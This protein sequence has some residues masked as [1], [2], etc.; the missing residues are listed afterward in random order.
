MNALS[1]SVVRA[2]PVRSLR[3]GAARSPACRVVEEVPALRHVIEKSSRSIPLVRVPVSG[4]LATRAAVHISFTP[5]E[6][7]RRSL[8]LRDVSR[9]SRC[10]S[11]ALRSRCSTGHAR[12]R[13][14]VQPAVLDHQFA[15]VSRIL[16]VVP[17]AQQPAAS[18]YVHTG[19]VC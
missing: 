11:S 10:G 16:A 1:R 18:V 9:V 17:D 3:A 6:V 7:A 2:D 8:S 4:M 13:H 19:A 14:V 15:T 12:R 5:G